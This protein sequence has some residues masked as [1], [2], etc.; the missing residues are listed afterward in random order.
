MAWGFGQRPPLLYR[1]HVGA[2]RGWEAA[3]AGE[4]WLVVC[5]VPEPCGG[6]RAR[7][8]A[9]NGRFG[10]GVLEV[11]DVFGVVMEIDTRVAAQE[12]HVCFISGV[13]RNGPFCNQLEAF[14]AR[15]YSS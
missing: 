7:L 13:E 4:A 8:A 15:M 2:R 11:A 9:Q 12:S 1:R 6:F 14:C 5:G 3:A 10:C